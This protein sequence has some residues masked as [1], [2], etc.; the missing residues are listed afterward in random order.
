MSIK[1]A[2][3][4]AGRSGETG[5]LSWPNMRY[6]VEFECVVA[7]LVQLKS[8]KLKI[9]LFV[10]SPFMELDWFADFGDYLTL[11]VSKKGERRGRQ[12]M[13]LP[14]A[15]KDRVARQDTWLVHQGVGGG[16]KER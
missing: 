1:S 3:Q 5:A 11:C 4:T 2:H 13:V 7:D 14:G 12:P 15:R 10:S 8:S 6:D 9:L 16:R